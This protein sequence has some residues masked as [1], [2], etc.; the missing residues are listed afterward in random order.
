MWKATSV[1]GEMAATV[2]G[3]ESPTTL[4]AAAG[5]LA[6]TAPACGLGHVSPQD[7]RRI[8]PRQDI[9]GPRD[10]MDSPKK[11]R[12]HGERTVFVQKPPMLQGV[13]SRCIPCKCFT[14]DPT[15]V[16]LGGLQP[17]GEPLLLGFHV[18]R[19]PILLLQ[20][21]MGHPSPTK[22]ALLWWL[23]FSTEGDCLMVDESRSY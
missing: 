4:A 11:F 6:L 1:H 2:T 23:C 22:I 13:Y 18:L 10:W 14:A 19:S 21:F 5:H 7:L 3:T 17:R 12:V 16:V 9:R 8:C 20:P 15:A